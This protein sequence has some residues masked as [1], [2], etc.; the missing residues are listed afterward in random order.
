S[1]LEARERGE[2]VHEEALQLIPGRRTQSTAPE[3]ARR[4]RRFEVGGFA[5]WVGRSAAENDALLRAASPNDLWL[6]AKDFAGSHVVVRKGGHMHIPDHVVQ[7]AAKLAARHSKAASEG[8]VEVT[9]TQV[10]HVRKP[11]GAPPGLASVRVSDTLTVD[12]EEGDR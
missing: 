1:A 3:E 6:H 2:A 12:L 9:F 7:A 8:R 4:F 10:K 5:L 11:R